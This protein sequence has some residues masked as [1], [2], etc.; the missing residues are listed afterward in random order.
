MNVEETKQALLNLLDSGPV[1]PHLVKRM[2]TNKLPNISTA[3]ELVA[4]ITENFEELSD[5]YGQPFWDIV[6]GSLTPEVWEHSGVL[7]NPA[8]IPETKLDDL[9]VIADGPLK[10]VQDVYAIVTYYGDL[11]LCVTE[12]TARVRDVKH[13]VQVGRFG[14]IIARG[15]TGVIGNGFSFLQLE[16][17]SRAR[18]SGRG[19]IYATDHSFFELVDGAAQ[20]TAR[21]QAQFVISGGTATIKVENDARGAVLSRGDE[22]HPLKITF[23]GNGV[24][25]TPEIEGPAIQFKHI[26]EQGTLI[27]KPNEGV[28]EE[29]LMRQ[30]VPRYYR[31]ETAEKM[32][33]ATSRTNTQKLH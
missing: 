6:K 11:D 29:E 12:G 15:E 27:Q 7:V 31:N 5:A 22:Y 32:Q 14:G 28:T 9:Y 1:D 19:N 20:I 2:L 8:V 30:I 26:S 18:V 25:Y 21:G 23:N 16:D 13:P 4:N 33:E 10:T 24:L 17:H 3:T